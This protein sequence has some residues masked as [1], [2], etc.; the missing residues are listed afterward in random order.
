MNGMRGH[1]VLLPV[2]ASILVGAVILLVLALGGRD[3][4]LAAQSLGNASEVGPTPLS[5]TVRAAD[6]ADRLLQRQRTGYSC[7][8]A[9]AMGCPLS[10]PIRMVPVFLVRDSDQTIHAFIGKDP[11]NGCALE[12]RPEIQDGVFYDVCHGALY[13]RHGRVVGGPS[14]WNLN[15]WSVEIR[16]GKLFVDPAKIITGP[17]AQRF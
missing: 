7:V 9:Q 1:G 11:R 12:W 13:D 3:D 14:P 5:A 16:D 4:A 6:G 8:G 10:T 15:E 17:L 2:A